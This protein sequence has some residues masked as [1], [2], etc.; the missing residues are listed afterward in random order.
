MIHTILL[1]ILGEFKFG[2][3]PQTDCKKILKEFKFDGSVSGLFI[4]EHCRLSLEVL[5]HELADL[6][7]IKLA[8]C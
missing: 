4:E 2:G 6:Q 7:E 5:E 3:W 8:L 1:K